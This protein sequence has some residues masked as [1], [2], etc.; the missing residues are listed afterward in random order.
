MV[1]AGDERWQG[2]DVPTGAVY[3]WKSDSTYVQEP[4]FFL[5]TGLD[6]PLPGDI[7]RGTSAGV[8][9]RFGHYRPHFSSRE[10]RED[11]PGRHLPHGARCSAAGIQLVRR[12]SWQP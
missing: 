9:G 10:H 7:T 1:F 4:P 3:D 12:P 5:G 11:Q 6:A 2:L 8:A